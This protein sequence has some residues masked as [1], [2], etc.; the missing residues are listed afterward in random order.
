M[1]YVLRLWTRSKCGRWNKP[2]VALD[3]TAKCEQCTELPKPR[4]LNRRNLLRDHGRSAALILA[5]V[6]ASLTGVARG[7]VITEFPVPT[8]SSSPSG[9]AAGPD[10]NLWF[11]EKAGNKIGRITT[12]GAITEFSIPTASS[13]PLGIAARPDGNLWFTEFGVNQIGR[14]TTA[15]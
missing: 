3:G 8:A 5:L 7:Q 10:G 11:T 4:S 6:V 15:G 2:E 14:I 9:I 13:S 1:D 12:A